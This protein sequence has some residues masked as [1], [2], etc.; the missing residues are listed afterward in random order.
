MKTSI[1]VAFSLFAGVAWAEPG[2]QFD[3]ELA[4]PP[5]AAR[6]PN[7]H[8]PMR[9]RLKLATTLGDP[10]PIVDAEGLKPS[11]SIIAPAEAA[12]LEAENAEAPTG[13]ATRK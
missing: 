9:P 6:A 8:A 12:A 5:V 11:D 1:L 13:P 3:L 2:P 7:A 10:G 4:S